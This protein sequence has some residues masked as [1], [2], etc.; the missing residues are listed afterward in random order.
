MPDEIVVSVDDV[1]QA[2]CS[3]LDKCPAPGANFQGTTPK[4]WVQIL[5]ERKPEFLQA[6]RAA[7]EEL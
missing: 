7:L 1:V 3:V 2:V 4:I 5:S 6:L